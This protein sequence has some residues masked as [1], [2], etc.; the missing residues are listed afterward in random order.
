MKTIIFDFDGTLADSLDVIIE[1]FDRMTGKANNLT[2]AE[3]AELRHLPIPVV[4]RRLGISPWAA[5]WLLWRG[6]FLMNRYIQ[7]VPPYAGV[8][9]VLRELHSA[10][11]KLIIVSTNSR[12]NIRVFLR[13]YGLGQYFSRVYGG[14]GLFSKSAALRKVLARNHLDTSD[15]IYIGDESRDIEACEAIGLRCIAVMW[16]FANAGF[17]IKHNPVALVEKPSELPEI[18]NRFL[19]KAG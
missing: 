6:R 11:Y 12:R 2:Q 19:G 16:G 17:L 5:P 15:C 10:G 4:A 9:T 3:M 13:Q 14:V 8:E 1:I 7:N 18:I